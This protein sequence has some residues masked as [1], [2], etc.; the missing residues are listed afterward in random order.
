MSKIELINDLGKIIVFLMMLLTFYLFTVRTDKKLSNRLFALFL[1][2]TSFDLTGLFIGNWNH[3][4]TISIL[5]LSSVLLQLPLFF[6]YV[7]SVCFAD[8]RLK[9][10]HLPHLFLFL[11]FLF[12]FKIAGF[13]PLA[14]STYEW[15]SEIQYFAYIT[16]IMVALYRYRKV[17]LN[18]YSNAKHSVYK[19]LV[20]ITVF[21]LI[22]HIFVM[23]RQVLLLF[24]NNEILLYIN[25]II[26]MNVLFI[27]CWFVL[28]ALY[29][30][31]I[32]T[33]VNS[34]LQIGNPTSKKTEKTTSIN[35]SQNEAIEIL[36]IHMKESKPYLDFDLTL[37]KLSSQITILEKELSSLINHH[38]G[39]HFF[40]FINEYRINDA[41]QILKDSTQ[42]DLTVLEILYQVGFNSKSSFYT[43]FKK[44]TNQTPKEFKIKTL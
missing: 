41:K 7:L 22:G 35:N 2:V 9:M 3:Y 4:P 6:L 33:G 20:Q 16:A 37:Q 39:K 42:K 38:I 21:F 30:P 32:F 12:V 43:A 5:K 28:K 25:L 1:I 15:I 24:K 26:S 44:S 40:D 10:K 19:W 29:H 11:S 31:S 13:S 27:T 23:A 18:N 36:L 14:L 8:F 34:T 17:Y